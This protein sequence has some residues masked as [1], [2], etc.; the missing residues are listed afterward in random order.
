MRLDLAATA[1]GLARSR[2]EAA[3]LVRRGQI[4]VNGTTVRR[5]S[6]IVCPGDRVT[7]DGDRC[8]YVSRGG[9]KLAAALDRF[10]FSPDGIDCL[11]I[12]S[13]TGGFTDC[14]L[15]R[16]AAHVVGVD[17]GHGQMDTRI[18]DDERVTNHEGVNAR[19]L[20]DKHFGRHFDAAV[21][22]VSFISLTLI[23]DHV[24]AQLSGNA[25]VVALLKPQFEVG[26]D[27]IGKNG[28]VRDQ[29]DR[30]AAVA[31][32]IA[33]ATKR[34]ALTPIGVLPSPITGGDGNIEYLAGFRACAKER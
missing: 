27:K 21:I 30:E 23:L 20:A 4:A 7:L 3:Q 9:V 6:Y 25:W 15:Q 17:V 5:S 16:G 28:V 22:D 26:A 34:C 8:P 33:Y 19:N 1:A 11:D 12:G 2:T 24:T 31:K 10:G 29:T 18:A 32:V 14:L 13:S